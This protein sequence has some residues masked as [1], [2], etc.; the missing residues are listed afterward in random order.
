MSD[1]VRQFLCVIPSLAALRYAAYFRYM[2][3]VIF[4]AGVWI[5]FSTAGWMITLDAVWLLVLAARC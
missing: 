1:L 2:D 3:D 4:L 5:N